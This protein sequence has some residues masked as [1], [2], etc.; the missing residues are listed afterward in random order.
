MKYLAI[1]RD[2]LRESLDSKVLY[3]MLGLSLIVIVLTSSISFEPT[4]AENG[5]LTILESFPG[6]QARTE[7]TRE[8][9]QP[10]KDGDKG[11][12]KADKNGDKAE[13]KPEKDTPPNDEFRERVRV[14][15]YTLDNFQKVNEAAKPWDSLYRFEL[16]VKE[17]EP[18]ALKLFVWLAAVERGDKELTAEEQQ[19]H[20]RFGPMLIQAMNMPPEA[21][22]QI[23]KEKL[24]QQ[25]LDQ[26]SRGQFERFII[27]QFGMNGSMDV[28]KVEILSLKEGGARFQVEAR[29]RPG[30]FR[31]W[32]HRLT[33]F[34]AWTLPGSVPEWIVLYTL[35]DWIVGWVGA[36]IAM[37]LSTIITAFFIPNM[38]RKGAVDLLLA[39]P[40]HR[41]SL[42]IYKYI[43]GLS[44]MFINTAVVVGGIWLVLGL[45]SGIWGPGFL[46]AIFVWTFEFAVIYAVSTLF[47][48][49]TRSPVVAILMTC[50]AWGVFLGVGKGY[51]IIEQTKTLID[52]PKWATITSDTV[53]FIMPPLKDLDV[54]LSREIT[55]DLL[56]A[57]NPARKIADES[58]SSIHWGQTIGFCLGWIVVLLGISCW[59]FATRDY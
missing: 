29:P 41:T 33:I 35:E 10:V 20:D 54:L 39:K 22:K 46:M 45:R 26:L 4:P 19:V 53:H 16:Q 50:L 47:A 59:W 6:A 11:E 36:G 25:R 51:Q 8:D 55:H 52:M 49:F 48:V 9:K 2:S 30:A 56:D 5:F 18:G 28:E 23:L 44:F 12:K 37:L 58:Y 21:V 57:D 7:I 24:M 13:K 31:S 17:H 32:P 38:L 1:L 27:S 15:E 3:F 40:I 34:W 14:V 42:L 43:G